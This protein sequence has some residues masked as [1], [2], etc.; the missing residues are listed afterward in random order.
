[1]KP[2]NM[3]ESMASLHQRRFYKD[4]YIQYTHYE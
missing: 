4:Y 2:E 3:E 1:M